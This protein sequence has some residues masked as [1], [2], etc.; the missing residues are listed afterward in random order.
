MLMADNARNVLLSLERR[1]AA[2]ILAG[3]KQV[4]LRRRPMQVSVGG[5]VWLYCKRPIASVIGVA[6]IRSTH[7][8]SPRA[9]W[10]QYAGVSGVTKEEFFGYF[11]GAEQAFALYLQRAT[12]L[13]E[14]VSL[15]TLRAVSAGFQPP[16]FYKRLAD[17]SALLCLLEAAT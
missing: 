5:T 9:M 7:L 15:T 17:D 1:H 3:A 16:Q 2:S 8:L 11:A 13:S 4:E 14:G 10:R 6:Q 12:K